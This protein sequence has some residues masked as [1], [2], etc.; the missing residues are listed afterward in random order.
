MN[1]LAV[2]AHPD[3]V[4]MWC[5]G[6]LRKYAEQ[7]HKVSI[8][9]VTNGRTGTHQ[10]TDDRELIVRREQEAL[11]ASKYYKADVQFLRQDDG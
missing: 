1:V 5:G 10:E 2:V 9:I 7:G 6:T 3:D 11:A 4:E 8:I